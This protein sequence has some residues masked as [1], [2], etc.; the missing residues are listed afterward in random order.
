MGSIACFTQIVKRKKEGKAPKDPAFLPFL[1]TL[2]QQPAGLPPRAD[3]AGLK[4]FA[5]APA[6]SIP[7]T[8]SLTG[9]F[10]FSPRSPL[11]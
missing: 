8:Y 7:L 11:K 1:Q 9:V 2:E 6:F 4:R 10:A 5:K 3:W